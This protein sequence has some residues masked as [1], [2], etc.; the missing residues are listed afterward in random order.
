MVSPHSSFQFSP[1]HCADPTWTLSPQNAPTTNNESSSDRILPL[2]TISS[3]SLQSKLDYSYKS[4]QSKTD[5]GANF[6]F[7]IGESF[8]RLGVENRTGTD[9][10]SNIQQSIPV[11]DKLR[12]RFGIFYTK[13]G[14]GFDYTLQP[15]V[16]SSEFYNFDELQMDMMLRYG[17]FDFMDGIGGVDNL[18]DKENREYRLGFSLFSPRQ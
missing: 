6:D 14:V 12:A 15:V 10:L 3:I 16:I 2:T 18:L 1:P 8:L 7:W 5:Y 17:I 9:K 13:P 11:Y 4:E